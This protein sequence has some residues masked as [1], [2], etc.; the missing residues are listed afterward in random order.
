MSGRSLLSPFHIITHVC[1][2]FLLGSVA[3]TFRVFL[4]PSQ[5]VDVT[6]YEAIPFGDLV[7][8]CHRYL[9]SHGVAQDVYLCQAIQASQSSTAQEQI[10]QCW[11][12]RGP[13][14]RL[15]C[16]LS[17]HRTWVLQGCNSAIHQM[18]SINR[19]HAALFAGCL[20]RD[21]SQPSG[22]GCNVAHS[23]MRLR[24][25]CVQTA[26]D[27]NPGFWRGGT[28]DGSRQAEISPA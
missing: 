25:S 10:E 19:G 23:H 22:S 24:I 8:S 14:M 11:M 7:Q 18:Q 2:R 6:R 3:P 26:P 4:L 27:A 20:V 5:S 16:C 21:A 15:L 12:V 1:L 13:L 28:D 17:G 9:T